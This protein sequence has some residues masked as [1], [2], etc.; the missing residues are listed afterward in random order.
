IGHPPARMPDV[1]W[2]VSGEVPRCSECWSLLAVVYNR[3]V[4]LARIAQA[5]AAADGA[6]SGMPANL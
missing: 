1:F 6:D 3:E 2:A 5:Q 4:A